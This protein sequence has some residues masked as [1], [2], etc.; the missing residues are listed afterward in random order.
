[1]SYLALSACFEYLCYGYVINIFLFQYIT[2]KVG[3]SAER[4]KRF[5]RW[6]RFAKFPIQVKTIMSNFYPLQLQVGEKL[7]F[8]HC[9]WVKILI[10]L[11]KKV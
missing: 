4:V 9:K 10:K 5:I 7:N 1:M 3:S 11:K 8:T 2:S 6:S